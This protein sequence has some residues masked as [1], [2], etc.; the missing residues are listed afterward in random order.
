MTTINPTWTVGAWAIDP[1]HSHVGFVV[2]HLGICNVGGSFPAVAGTIVTAEQPEDSHVQATIEAASVHTAS[3][4]RDAHLRSADFFDVER[5]PVWTFQSTAV[6]VGAEEWQLAGEL[7]IRGTTRP[8]TFTTRLPAFGP[9]NKPGS[10]RAGF[11]ARGAVDRSDFGLSFNAP[12]PGGGVV[13][14]E[15]VQL[16][17]EIEAERID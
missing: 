14:G 1:E 6:N 13:L 4:K 10:V 3:E 9:G 15:R 11:S 5:H 2:R 7:T 8:V 16:V 12:I 17:L